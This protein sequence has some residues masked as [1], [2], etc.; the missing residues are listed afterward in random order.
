MEEIQLEFA[1]EA[2][3]TNQPPVVQIYNNDLPLSEP[4][5]IKKLTELTFN[6][7]LPTDVT[8]GYIRIIRSNHDEKTHQVCHL[9]GLKID[10]IDLTRIMN[11]S[12]FLP[13]YPEIWHMEQTQQG[14]HWPDH[15][16]GWTSWGWNGVWELVYQTPVYT[17]LLK[18]A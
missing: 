12:R 17:W 6:L 5:E 4:I 7:A 14:I 2:E 10:S 16:N 8:D 11:H 18:H 9:S 15:H 3:W 1:F 13:K